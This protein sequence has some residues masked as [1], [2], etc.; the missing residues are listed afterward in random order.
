MSLPHW[1]VAWNEPDPDF[2][3]MTARAR[4][5]W[6]ESREIARK[7]HQRDVEADAL[8]KQL[9]DDRRA[10]RPQV[11]DRNFAWW[12]AQAEAE[13]ERRKIPE[14]VE[15]LKRAKDAFRAYKAAPTS[16]R[17]E[18]MERELLL[19][20]FCENAGVTKERAKYLIASME[21]HDL[22]GRD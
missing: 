22:Y 3:R 15:R 7:E 6:L 17:I 20:V 11:E 16:N 18:L 21:G 14:I 10:A 8:R 2:T 1:A 12:A 9:D 4:L 5:G 19:T 13:A